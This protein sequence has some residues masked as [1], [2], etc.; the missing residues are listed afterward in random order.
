MD[1]VFRWSK[2]TVIRKGLK[3]SAGPSK[4]F[5]DRAARCPRGSKRVPGF[6]K[7]SPFFSSVSCSRPLDHFQLSRGVLTP[8][9]ADRVVAGG[10]YSLDQ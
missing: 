8:P 9:S 6:F 5:V 1:G 4:N 2:K 7:L 10:V 3:G